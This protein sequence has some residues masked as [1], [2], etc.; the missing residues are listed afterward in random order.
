MS[1]NTRQKPITLTIGDRPLS[2]TSI[3]ELEYTLSG[4]IGLSASQ[5]ANLIPASSEALLDEAE[6]FKNI[7][8]NLTNTLAMEHDE[9]I[10]KFFKE[11]DLSTISQDNDWRAIIH[12]FYGIHTDLNEYRKLALMK[13]RQYLTARHDT[14][15]IIYASRKEQPPSLATEAEKVR[16]L[17]DLTSLCDA[18]D[19][20][21]HFSLLPKGQTIEI[22]LTSRQSVT[23]LLAKHRFSIVRDDKCRFI[24]ENGRDF[25][26][27]HGKNVIGRDTMNDVVVDAQYREISRRHLI[28]ET[29]GLEVI[30]LT[31]ISSL[32]TSVPHE[33]LNTTLP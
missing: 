12:A 9:A 3:D 27:H 21:H 15:Q 8:N 32:G 33:F 14:A 4:R 31:D 22:L 30:R 6:H 7:E 25:A 28:V 11:L 13:Y 5:I 10:E 26:L 1:K 29:D 16:G 2:F 18:S 19:S 20:N 24:D 17:V 23:V